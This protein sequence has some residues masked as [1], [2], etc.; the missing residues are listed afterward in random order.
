MAL[1]LSISLQQLSGCRG[2]KL[3]EETG[4]FSAAVVGGWGAPNPEIA[5]VDSA[6]LLVTLPESDTPIAI[7]IT[8][9][10]AAVFPTVDDTVPLELVNTD[11]GL[12]ATATLPYGIWT[13]V[14]T[15]YDVAGDII[16]Q[17]TFYFIIDCALKCCLDK[18]LATLDT[19]DCCDD[20]SANTKNLRVRMAYIYLEAAHAAASCGKYER[21]QALLDF[22]S[23]VCA[24]ASCNCG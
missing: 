13:F 14:Y 12:A 20:K 16:A 1:S 8:T 22:V 24:E 17:G 11:F 2:I 19:C 3:Y 6:I 21:A 10:F 15:T 23:E 5:D 18:L 4:A 7:D 9:D